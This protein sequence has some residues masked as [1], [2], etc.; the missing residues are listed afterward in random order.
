MRSD[1]IKKGLE[2]LPHR[3]LLHATGITSEEMDKPFIAIASSFTDIVPGHIHMRRLERA[4]EKGIHSAGG[5]SFVF[6][7]PA[8]CDGIAM[9]HRGMHYSLASRELIADSV[10]TFVE[11]HSLDGVVLLTACDKITPG[12]LMAAARLDLPC[13]V[14]TAGPML[15]GRHRGKRLSLVRDTFEAVGRAQ[16]GLIDEK[17]LMA[18]E[19]EACPGG[20]SC[21]G[22]YTAN[23]M[24]CVTEALGLSLSGMAASLAVS[25]KKERLAYESGQ[26]V[27]ELVKEGINSRRF[28]APE[29]FDNAI[30]I[31]MAL[32][33]STNACLHIP[34]IAYSAGVQL[35][36]ERIDQISRK[37]PH[38]AD[39]RPGGEY[40]M[41]DLEYAGGIP[42]VLKRLETL[43]A[44]CPT[45]SGKTIHQ[46]A[47][48]AEVFD[49]DVIRPMNNPYHAEG[50]IA[51]LKGTLA[52][53]GAVVK[54]TAVSEKS[55]VF[56]GRAKV[57][58]SEE[59][60]MQ[61]IMGKE[62]S[63][64]DVVVVRYEGP[65]GGPGMREMLSPTAAV[66]GMGLSDE[67]ALVTDGRFSGGTRGPCVGHISPEA[68]SGGPIAYVRDGDEI[69]IDIPSR[70]LDVKISPEEMEKR[71]Q[72]TQ[73]KGPKV[74]EGWLVRYARM[75]SSAAQGAVLK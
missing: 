35:P 60:A 21:Q 15:T 17:E 30:A 14:V 65:R 52:P 12:M 7:V 13:I 33:G 24:A 71:K 9:G 61:A 36:L 67:V 27:V 47:A 70:R 54:Q 29:A 51:V 50:G 5:V 38:I 55:K 2:R 22:V 28:F 23:T 48:G 11:A 45:V 4:I 3:A 74:N 1:R 62:I 37:T 42:A 57:Y 53:D 6:G 18:L 49:E 31:D 40:F 69:T 19:M 72:S 63:P 20:G 10:E 58:D 39:L 43:L 32:G 34:A 68:A 64:G 73:I 44:D 41:E 59:E 25:A 46:I 66:T 26:R 56:A 75:V 16:A 8:V